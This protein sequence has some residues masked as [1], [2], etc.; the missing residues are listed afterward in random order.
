[1]KTIRAIIKPNS[2][3]GPLIE[4]CEDSSFL[5]YVREPATDGK[6]NQAAIDL[7]ATHFSVPK[8]TISLRTGASSRYKTFVIA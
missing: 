5:L 1:M 7:L 4:L 8:S 2:K 6:A 3:K